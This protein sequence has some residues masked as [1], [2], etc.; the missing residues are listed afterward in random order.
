L[1]VRCG[2]TSRSGGGLGTSVTDV[3]D[4]AAILMELVAAPH[5]WWAE[6]ARP[7]HDTEHADDDTT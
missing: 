6:L 7:M 2:R 3:V 5:E 4:S 1:T